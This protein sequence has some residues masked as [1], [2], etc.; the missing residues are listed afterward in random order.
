MVQ[1][2]RQVTEGVDVG[3]LLLGGDKEICFADACARDLLGCGDSAGDVD[4]RWAE[5]RQRLDSVLDAPARV[6]ATGK[7]IEVDIAEHRLR[8]DFYPL[9]PAATTGYV[10][11]VR[12]PARVEALETDLLLATQLR[13]LIGLFPGTAHELRGLL[14]TI[15]I[16][17]ELLKETARKEEAVA[18]LQDR[19]TRYV[20]AMKD[21]VARLNCSFDKLYAEIENRSDVRENFDLCELIRHVETLLRAKAR[22]QRVQLTIDVPGHPVPLS[23]DRAHLK[24]ALLNIALN[25]LE[26]MPK[27][28]RLEVRLHVNGA[29]AEVAIQDS[30][31]GMSPELAACVGTMRYSTK[32]PERGIGLRVARA[33]VESLGGEIVIS[34]EAAHGTCA[35]ITLPLSS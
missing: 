24:Q 26:A 13:G 18:G 1:T 6:Q 5:V 34:T 17:L 35:R 16:N 11:L 10:A 31:E 22:L 29:T 27:G 2:A 33:V 4:E 21:S 23:G 3:V 25:G 12:D 15:I 7:R 8:F 19:R 28:G 14:N 30:G 32:S 9:D 20:A